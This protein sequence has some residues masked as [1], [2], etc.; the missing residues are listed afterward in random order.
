MTIGIVAGAAF[1][2][3]GAAAPPVANGNGTT[4][5]FHDERWQSIVLIVRPPAAQRNSQGCAERLLVRARA[6]LANAKSQLFYRISNRQ[7]T[8]SSAWNYA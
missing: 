8:V 5:Q 7:R 6:A 1:A 3:I 2:A 4:H